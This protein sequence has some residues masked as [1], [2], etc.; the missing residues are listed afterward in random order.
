MKNL[1]DKEQ[2]LIEE[3]IRSERIKEEKLREER[4]KEE[5]LR[6]ERIKEEK[7]REER[8]KEERSEEERI[9]EEKI[10]EERIKEEKLDIS[11]SDI[12]FDFN[13]YRYINTDLKHFN[14]NELI[15]HFL[16]HGKF[17]RRKFCKLNFDVYEY[18]KNY[19]NITNIIDIKFEYSYEDYRKLNNKVKNLT[20][21][22]A[23][24]H[25]N[26]Q[27][28]D[29]G[30]IPCKIND[31]FNW[32]FYSIKYD[33]LKFKTIEQLWQ[34]YIYFGIKEKRQLNFN[35]IA[36]YDISK[37]SVNM[38]FIYVPEINKFSGVPKTAIIYVYYNRQ[39]ELANETNLA[40]FIR[41]AVLK[42]T[43]NDY[44][45]IINNKICEIIFPQQKNLFIFKN[46]NCYDFEAY[47]LGINYFKHKYG[48]DFNKIKRF[49][50]MNCS[51]VGPFYNNGHWLDKFE[52]KLIKDEAILCSTVMYV[53][54][55]KYKRTPGYFNYFVNDTNI[56]NILMRNV[57]IKHE[58]KFLCVNNGEYGLA[59]ILLDNRYKITTLIY[60]Y[61]SNIKQGWK[62]DRDNNLN[63]YSLFDLV[64]SKINWRSLNGINR[65]SRPVKYNEILYY[66][67]KT[68]NF[69]NEPF[70]NINYNLIPIQNKTQNWSSKQHF[71]IYYGIQEEFI[72][73]PYIHN[74]NKL[75][76]Y[77][78]SDK[79]NLFRDYS[80]KA[81]NTLSLLGYNVVICTTCSNFVN[82]KNIP[83]QVVNIPNAKNDIYMFK[84]YINNN[85]T[86]ITNYNY[87]LLCNDTILFPIHGI[88]NMEN[89]MKTFMN[90]CDYWGIWNSP[91]CKTHIMSP[92]LHFNGNRASSNCTS[93]NC[94]SSNTN[95]IFIDL[96]NYL[97]TSSLIEFK[98]AQNWEINLV[99]YFS[100][101]NYKYKVVVDYNTLKNIKHTCPIMHPEVF[102]QWINRSEVFAIKWKYMGNYLN[103]DKLNNP[104]LNN[105][106]RFLHFNHT[107]P[108]GKPEEQN[109]YKNPL[110][111]I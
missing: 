38:K 25:F 19:N 32:L 24:Y 60:N 99:S 77:G 39:G 37:M 63:N 81:V 108:K 62:V 86:E 28:R 58:N 75:A 43:I 59:K 88:K 50:I 56:L 93:S 34:H 10:N 41:E 68:C 55:N 85:F 92:F 46:N 106:L 71:Y 89:T 17:E 30:L 57:L 18:I 3:R 35:T 15:Q 110:K 52:Q 13:Y 26:N 105:L 64:F 67:N 6:E 16:C 29:L 14:N 109:V 65:D 80:V 44:L 104:Y 9:E 49:V 11:I 96:K 7:L 54:N 100:N 48:N 94:T 61:N 21:E 23:R 91:E 101:L 82:V 78:H 1:Y 70:T 74:Y 102:P 90:S 111:Y 12:F 2:F 95:S 79:D 31:N 84:C 27:G 4:I 42:D 33:D 40:F 83:Y 66:I 98:E 107:G 73:Y 20:E 47:G 76:L 103:K 5:K 53:L 22:N 97:N 45:I 87:L 8:I 69:K 72:V 51:V 36:N